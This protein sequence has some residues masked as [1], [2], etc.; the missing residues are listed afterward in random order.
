MILQS[1]R[2]TADKGKG[3]LSPGLCRAATR[4]TPSTPPFRPH[5]PAPLTSHTQSA[6]GLRHRP[7]PCTVRHGRPIRPHFLP[8]SHLPCC[9]RCPPPLTRSVRCATWP[10]PPLGRSCGTPGRP[11]RGPMVR[12]RPVSFLLAA[13]QL[14]KLC[15]MPGRSSDLIPPPQFLFQ[16]CFPPPHILYLCPPSLTPSHIAGCGVGKSH[17]AG[18]AAAAAAVAAAAA[19]AADGV[20]ASD[21]PGPIVLPRTLYAS[22]PSGGGRV[23]VCGWC[24]RT[25]TAVR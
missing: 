25:A 3:S 18:S 16:E 5:L 20:R 21:Y 10:P 1:S 11:P 19:N 15:V 23:W 4:A 7:G 8:H 14:A 12:Q 6:G 13:C 22:L 9:N 17:K 2:L 24:G